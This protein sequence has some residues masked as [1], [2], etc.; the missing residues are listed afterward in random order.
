MDKFPVTWFDNDDDDDNNNNNNNVV[1][2]LVLRICRLRFELGPDK[3]ILLWLPWLTYSV[4]TNVGMSQ[5]CFQ[6]PSLEL[7]SCPVSFHGLYGAAD[8]Y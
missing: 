4:Q 7:S 1:T 2:E 6:S 8:G 5:D 3:L